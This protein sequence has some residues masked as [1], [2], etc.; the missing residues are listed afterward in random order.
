MLLS[1]A[2]AHTSVCFSG[3]TTT[4]TLLS[5]APTK[6]PLSFTMA[7]P[8]P[9]PS[10]EVLETYY[11]GIASFGKLCGT[12][13]PLFQHDAPYQP[14]WSG[15]WCV[16]KRLATVG[17]HPIRAYFSFGK[18]LSE[19]HLAT[20]IITAMEESGLPCNSFDILRIGDAPRDSELPP[21]ILINVE[22]GQ[23][24]WADGMA[25]AQRCRSEVQRFGIHDVHCE[26][27]E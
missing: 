6:A 18:P 15:N 7:S 3:T 12:T 8:P 5:P 16:G 19:Q 11:A 17:S 2:M 21:K 13:D 10:E 25:L 23:V 27:Y 4:T 26:V 14:A 22:A 9:S 1:S 20:R 24:S